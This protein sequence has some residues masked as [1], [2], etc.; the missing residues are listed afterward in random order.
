M[1]ESSGWHLIWG[2][3]VKRKDSED[4]RIIVQQTDKTSST[5]MSLAGDH[6]TLTINNISQCTQ[7]SSVSCALIKVSVWSFILKG[8]IQGANSPEIGYINRHLFNSSV[9][10]WFPATYG[11]FATIISCFNQLFFVFA[12]EAWRDNWLAMS[13]FV[14]Q[15]SQQIQC[16]V[17]AVSEYA[18]ETAIQKKR[19]NRRSQQHHRR[20]ELNDFWFKGT[21]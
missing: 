8:K 12:A 20:N 14:C 16:F 18:Y 11:F 6:R 15:L 21:L 13:L 10:R 4:R 17:N 3:V 19:T 7:I 1:E 5:H 2:N 9:V